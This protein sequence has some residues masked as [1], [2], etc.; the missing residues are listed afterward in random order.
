MRVSKS[1]KTLVELMHVDI[2]NISLGLCSKKYW[3]NKVIP[4]FSDLVF[5]L[6]FLTNSLDQDELYSAVREGSLFRVFLHFFLCKRSCDDVKD[7]CSICSHVRQRNFQKLTLFD[8]FFV[9][10]KRI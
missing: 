1:F 10:R 9:I 4:L 3:S 6:D 7:Y 2:L 5:E 8:D